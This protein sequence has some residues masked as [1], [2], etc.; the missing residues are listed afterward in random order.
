MFRLI[1][2]DNIYTLIKF[3]GLGFT[4]YLSISEFF[5]SD[6]DIAIFAQ[7]LYKAHSLPQD[8]ENE[9]L[10]CHQHHMRG[11][12]VD[13]SIWTYV[14]F[15]RWKDLTQTLEVAL[16]LRSGY[17]RLSCSLLWAGCN[18][19]SWT[20]SHEEIHLKRA[21]FYQIQE[22]DDIFLEMQ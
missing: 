9:A 21:F 3:K 8:T 18:T 22:Q 15:F 16:P 19:T 17:L 6:L 5:T 13:F 2:W 1:V 14:W 20:F 12:R 4:G 11:N 10:V 7:N